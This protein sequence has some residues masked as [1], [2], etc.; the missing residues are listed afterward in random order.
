MVAAVVQR[1]IGVPRRA[2]TA[3]LSGL[4]LILMLV[5][6]DKPQSLSSEALVN[7]VTLDTFR[8]FHLYLLHK[9][10]TAGVA[11]TCEVVHDRE[12]PVSPLV[13]QEDW[14]PP[15]KRLHRQAGNKLASNLVYLL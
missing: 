3:R 4:H 13:S 1:A 10:R 12:R 14:L 15:R 6:E 5:K 9:I 8:L 11:L 2:A 7:L